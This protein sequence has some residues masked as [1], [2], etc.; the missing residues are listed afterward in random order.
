MMKLEKSSQFT[1]TARRSPGIQDRGPVGRTTVRDEVLLSGP[2]SFGQ[3]LMRLPWSG[4]VRVHQND[5]QPKTQTHQEQDAAA[6]RVREAVGYFPRERQE[7]RPYLT[8]NEPY[9]D[10]KTHC[11]G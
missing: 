1:S 11:A 9:D 3:L 6:P 4:R 5:L 8:R 7:N 10:D 2:P